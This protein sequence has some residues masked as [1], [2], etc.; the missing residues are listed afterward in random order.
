MLSLSLL[1]CAL[2]WGFLFICTGRK[3]EGKPVLGA[4]MADNAVK[5]VMAAVRVKE[6]NNNDHEI[7]KN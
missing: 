5:N 4:L 3:N 7:T 2:P 1:F 6:E